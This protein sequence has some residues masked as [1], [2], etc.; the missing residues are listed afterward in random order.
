[1]RLFVKVMSNDICRDAPVAP[2][3][4]LSE[5]FKVQSVGELRSDL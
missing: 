5:K 1:M 4:V 3:L 2:F